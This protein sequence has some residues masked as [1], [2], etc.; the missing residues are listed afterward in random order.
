MKYLLATVA[1]QLWI[2]F[3]F[4]FWTFSYRALPCFTG[5]TGGLWLNSQLWCISCLLFIPLGILS[6]RFFGMIVTGKW[7][8]GFNSWFGMRTFEHVRSIP[9][10][11]SKDKYS[12]SYLGVSKVAKQAFISYE[13]FCNNLL[14][15]H[16]C[17]K[18][19]ELVHTREKKTKQYKEEFRSKVETVLVTNC[20]IS[21]NTVW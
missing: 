14:W 15:Q 20:A 18:K 11:S 7:A 4:H 12:K 3:V 16:S 13:Y 1:E 6:S 21:F 2:H 8:P 9:Y 10:S 5:Q 17:E 19:T